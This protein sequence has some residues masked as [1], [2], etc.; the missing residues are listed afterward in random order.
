MVMITKGNGRRR[1][2]DCLQGHFTLLSRPFWRPLGFDQI[3]PALRQR[4]LN[5]IYNPAALFLALN[6]FASNLD[7]DIYEFV[8]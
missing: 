7:C 2:H 8:T 4:T 1:Q 6:K 3:C 5:Y